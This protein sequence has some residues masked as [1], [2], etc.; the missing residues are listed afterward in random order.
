MTQSSLPIYPHILQAVQSVWASSG[1]EGP[2][3]GIVPLYDLIAN[4][5]IW[6]AE[7][8]HLSIEQAANYLAERT[9][10]KPE[11]GLESRGPLSGFFYAYLYRAAFVG[12]ILVE[13]RDP[14]VRRRF[15]AAHE[16]GHYILH[17]E[18]WLKQLTPDQAE[19]GVLMTDAMIYADQTEGASG[20]TAGTGNALP[21]HT[22]VVTQQPAIIMSDEQEAEANQFAAS[23]LMPEHILR[24]RIAEFKIPVGQP[25][26]YLASRLASEFLVSKEAMNFRLTSLGL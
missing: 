3:V 20:F 11:L 12:C 18:P 15:S 6:V 25:R 21:V 23:L 4:Y 26:G 7:V 19:E 1:R 14:V 9:G 13:K 17:F 10:Q 8:E 2:G 22:G 24:E 16:L 5:P